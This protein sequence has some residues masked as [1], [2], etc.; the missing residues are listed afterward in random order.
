MSTL[1]K[2]VDRKYTLPPRLAR[3]EGEAALDRA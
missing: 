1:E 2:Y 3:N